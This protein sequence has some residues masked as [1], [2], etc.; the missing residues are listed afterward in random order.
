MGRCYNSAVINAP[1]ETVWE[2]INDFHDL[3]WAP[4]VI[5]KVDAVGGI[6]GKAPGAK[7]VLNDLFHGTLI[8]IDAELKTFSYGI[9]DG[10]EPVSK[11]S[12]SDYIGTVRLHPITDNDTTFIEWE[13]TYSSAD[14][15]AVGD[16]CSPIYQ[17]LLTSL[18][19]RF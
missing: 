19:N 3:S 11:D 10:P 17:A 13:S 4:E 2:R 9:D 6:N 15:G 12:V 8:S 18:K 16:F 5:T 7:R 1:L 14:D